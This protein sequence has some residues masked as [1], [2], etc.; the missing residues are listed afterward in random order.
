MTELIVEQMR[1]ACG[2]G[3]V[4]HEFSELRQRFWVEK[5]SSTIRKVIG[6]CLQCR[7]HKA[8]TLTQKMADSPPDRMQIFKPAFTYTDVD[9]RSPFLVKQGGVG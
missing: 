8:K 6:D 3:G 7:K 2:H 5:G 4:N 1:E 9:Y